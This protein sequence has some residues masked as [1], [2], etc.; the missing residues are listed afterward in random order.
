MTDYDT[1]STETWKVRLPSDWTERES[2]TNGSTYFESSDATKGA[3]F[4]TWRFND[5][6]RSPREI[7]ESFHRVELRSFDKM[8]DRTW[9]CLDEWI[10]D[11]PS[12]TLGLDCLDRE[13]SYRI[14]CQL[15]IRL[16]WLVR[17]SFHDY[18]CSDYDASREFFRPIIQS[19]EIHHED[20]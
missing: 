19:L 20:A 8:E 10:T 11:A 13:H 4:T 3:Y 15:I 9:Q 5:D 6:P 18:Y 2:V 14:V 16:P 12:L 7:L 17:S 1:I